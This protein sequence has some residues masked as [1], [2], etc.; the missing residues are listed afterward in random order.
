MEDE[1]AVARALVA[2]GA[3]DGDTLKWLRKTAEAPRGRP[4]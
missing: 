4:C 3:A 2:A 1:A